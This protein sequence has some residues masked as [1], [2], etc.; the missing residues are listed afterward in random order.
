MSSTFANMRRHYRIVMPTLTREPTFTPSL[1]RTSFLKGS[2]YVPRLLSGKIEVRQISSETL[3]STRSD[4]N[5]RALCPK[6]SFRKSARSLGRFT[7]C[8]AC[9]PSHSHIFAVK[10]TE[11]LS[12]PTPQLVTIHFGWLKISKL[13]ARQALE[14]GDYATGDTHQFIRCN[15]KVVVPRSRCSPHHVIHAV[16]LQQARIN[17]HA[18]LCAVT[19]GRHP[20]VGFGNPRVR[21]VTNSPAS[22]LWTTMAVKCP[23]EGQTRPSMA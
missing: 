4:L 15:R 23:H 1:F 11:S 20:A 10:K 9:G 8:H 14:V 5:P 21:L 16:V 13:N 12:C 18:Q 2:K 3:T 17:K 6:D 22:V 7:K 19:K